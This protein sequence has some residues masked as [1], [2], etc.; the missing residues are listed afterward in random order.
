[1]AWHR[2]AVSV[3]MAVAT[4]LACEVVPPGTDLASSSDTTPPPFD[5]LPNGTIDSPAGSLVIAE[6]ESAIFAGTGSD[7]DGGP[8]A[9]AWDFEARR[10]G[11]PA[12][13]Q[14][15][16]G[17]VTFLIAG[18]FNVTLT[19][20]DDEG[21]VD[22][23][24]ATVSVEVRRNTTPPP[25]SVALD[26]DSSQRFQT[27]VGMELTHNFYH[28][29]ENALGPLDIHPVPQPIL[30]AIIAD[31]VDELGVTAF[32]FANAF[33]MLSN[34]RAGLECDPNADAFPGDP[35]RKCYAD[36]RDDDNDD[37]FV[38]DSSKIRW[39]WFDPYVES[40]LIPMR[41]R[42]VGRGEPFT[43]TLTAIAWSA[44]QWHEPS[45]DPGQE[46]AEIMLACLDRLK[47]VHGVVPDFVAVYNEPDNFL[48]SETPSDVIRAVE[49]LEA[50]MLA[51]GH[52]A[53]LRYPDVE[54]LGNAMRWIN[55]ME[56]QAPSL[57]N[58]LGV[59]SFHG[60]GGFDKGTLNA[61]RDKARALGIPVI[62]SEWWSTD[63]HPLDIHKA[64]TEAD[65]V[66]YQPY[67]MSEPQ[68]DPTRRGIY[69]LRYSGGTAPLFNF[70][71][72]QRQN[73]WYEIRQ[74]SAFIRPGD[75]RVG[76]TSGSASLLPV[77]FEKPD[78]RHVV[79][80]INQAGGS[81]TIALTGLAP[82]RYAVT[83]TSPSRLDGTEPTQSVAAGAPLVLTL[84]GASVTTIHPE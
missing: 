18:R 17:A 3:A 12:S 38:L 75:V 48:S 35:D 60:Y 29:D 33:L 67:L 70:T 16:P 23:S 74:Y 51:R 41:D 68:N 32:D 36:A 26:I 76:V 77:A 65:V 44:W 57:L 28:R 11:V 8:V 82:G 43:L 79:V 45:T 80:V 39:N 24:P 63:Y 31:A 56:Q 30:D 50:G 7:P 46:Y 62:Q 21:S 5:Q 59:I 27:W 20:T 49:N 69:G 84:D 83:L 58:E 78:G 1:M 64:M 14:E 15:D 2:L 72:W 13:S 55:S 52:S 19:V 37:P 66:Q 53:S 9:F 40:V 54:L 81:Q 71:G 73:D 61:L 22:P 34:Q 47:D 25:G 6:G 42:V 10:S 4:T